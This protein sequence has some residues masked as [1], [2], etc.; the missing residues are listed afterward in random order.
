MGLHQRASAWLLGTAAENTA[1]RTPG[2]FLPC[3]VISAV[4]SH[5]YRHTT[6]VLECSHTSGFVT[7]ATGAHRLTISQIWP[8][9]MHCSRLYEDEATVCTASCFKRKTRMQGL[10]RGPGCCSYGTLPRLSER[11]RWRNIRR[12]L[13][14]PPSGGG[15]EDSKHV[16]PFC[17]SLSSLQAEAYDLECV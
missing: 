5:R 13:V 11:A 4:L 3:L 1:A 15:T 12:S 14:K 16:F 2:F 6:R 9:R 10:L 17:G 8:P 7:T